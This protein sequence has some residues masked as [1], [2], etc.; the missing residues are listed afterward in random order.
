MASTRDIRFPVD[1]VRALRRTLIREMGPDAA[2]RA[3]QEAGHAA[4]DA[5]FQRLG[6]D[7]DAIGQ[8][9]QDTF[10]HRL[11]DL[12][13]ELGWGTVR[14]ETPHPGVG[15]L[16]ASEW[17]EGE[18]DGGAGAAPF[19]TGV[20]ANVLGR[21]AGGEVSVLQVP[22]EADDGRCLRFLFGAP[23]VLDRLYSGLREGADVETSLGALG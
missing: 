14:H 3:L 1:S 4:G 10:W 12:F 11:A 21:A 13:R 6:E 16:V 2:T 7:A 18:E 19:T 9:P 17:F 8:T 20:L 15:A 5:L 22:C 23:A